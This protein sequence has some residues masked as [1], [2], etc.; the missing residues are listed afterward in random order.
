MIDGVDEAC[1]PAASPA[2]SSSTFSD[3]GIGDN[4]LRARRLTRL[5]KLDLG[6]NG[7]GDD[8]ARTELPSPA[9]PPSTSAAMASAPTACLRAFMPSPASPTLHPSD[10]GIGDDGARAL[11]APQPRLTTLDLSQHRRRRRPRSPPSPAS[12]P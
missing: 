8:G 2:S 1:A 7:I 5:T 9:S 4:H 10:N 6:G 11:A 3:N 12:P